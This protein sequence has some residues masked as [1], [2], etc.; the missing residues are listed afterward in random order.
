[1]RDRVL[2]LVLMGVALVIY[3]GTLALPPSRM[4]PLGPSAFPRALAVVIFV[5][6]LPLLFR[7]PNPAEATPESL[8]DDPE[9]D[10]VRPR[11]WVAVVTML[12]AA[13]LTLG[14]QFR[15][16]SFA[17]AATLFLAVV[18]TVLTGFRLRALP[19]TLVIAPLTGF[20]LQYLF[21]RVF[22]IYLP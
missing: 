11:P 2:A 14:L 17:L 12:A 5:L 19:A 22:V 20:G 9:D 16:I 13:A 18:M 1:M 8:A 15:V 7:R 4:E 10:P 6:S 21:T 3:W